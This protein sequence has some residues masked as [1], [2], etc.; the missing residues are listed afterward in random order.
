MSMTRH[1]GRVLKRRLFIILALG[2]MV[3]SLSAPAV[4]GPYAQQAARVQ[5]N[6]GVLQMIAMG[7]LESQAAATLDAAAIRA[8]HTMA[9]EGVTVTSVR[10]VTQ[11]GQVI[12]LVAA[13]TL[14]NC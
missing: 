8:C 7:G 4:A 12:R 13:T 9:S 10:I 2:A 5:A 3:A 11:S 14:A 6:G 1:Y